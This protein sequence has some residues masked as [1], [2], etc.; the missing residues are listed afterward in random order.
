MG[1]ASS[2]G[3]IGA[4]AVVM[5]LGGFIVVLAGE[6]EVEDSAY[7]IAVRILLGFVFAEGGGEAVPGPDGLIS[8]GVDQRSWR[9]EIIGFDVGQVAGLVYGRDRQ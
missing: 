3:I 8:G 2:A 1:V 5:E 7:A 6:S 4:E 9:V